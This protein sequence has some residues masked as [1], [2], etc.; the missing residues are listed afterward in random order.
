MLC[1]FDTDRH[2]CGTVEVACLSTANEQCRRHV[3]PQLLN[4]HPHPHS[5]PALS[6]P[7]PRHLHLPCALRRFLLTGSASISGARQPAS[8]TSRLCLCHRSLHTPTVTLMCD[9]SRHGAG[10]LTPHAAVS[11]TNPTTCHSFHLLLAANSQFWSP[12]P[13]S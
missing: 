12:P 4:R 10:P 3:I 5:S 9:V 13:S 1:L 8:I 7:K 2:I 11:T 6:L